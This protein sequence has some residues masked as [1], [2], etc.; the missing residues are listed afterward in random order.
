[1]SQDKR[2]SPWEQRW[3]AMAID[4]TLVSQAEQ[5]FGATMRADEVAQVARQDL[6][7]KEQEGGDL[8]VKNVLGQGGMG[9][10]WLA[11]Q[12]SIGREVAVKTVRDDRMSE[13]ARSELLREAWITG[14]LE[15]PN[16][17]PVHALSEREGRP[18]FVMKRVEGTAWLDAIHDPRKLPGHFAGEDVLEAHLEI[19]EQVCHAVHFAHSRD[20]LHRDIKPENVMLGAFGEVY[21]VDWG[22]AIAMCDIPGASGIPTLSHLSSPAGTPCFMAPEMAGV[23]LQNFGPPT[24]VYLLGATLHYLLT[25]RGR[26]EGNSLFAVMLAAY[27]SDPFDYGDDVPPMLAAICNTATQKDPALRYASAEELR[28]AIVEFR[29]HRDS[30]RVTRGALARLRDLEG[31]AALSEPGE[32]MV[33]AYSLYGECRFGFEQALGIWHAN[34]QAIAGLESAR[35]AMVKLELSQ[36]NASAARSMLTEMSAPAPK[37]S[38]RVL[39]L[40][41]SQAA[42]HVRIAALEQRQLQLDPVADRRQRGLAI[43]SLALTLLLL[44]VTQMVLGALTG[45]D[46]T[47]WQTFAMKTLDLA[48]TMGFVVGILKFMQLNRFGKQMILGL[49]WLIAAGTMMRLACLLQGFSTESSILFESV[50]YTGL[51]VGYG[52]TLRERRL[53]WIGPFCLLSGVGTL[54]LPQWSWPIRTAVNLVLMIMLGALWVRHGGSEQEEAAPSPS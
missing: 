31:L 54:L 52:I 32:M 16:I 47:D 18:L 20:I 24:D 43:I 22:I 1:M 42:E 36:N 34:P 41:R 38:E 35:A 7:F 53:L 17:I 48:V 19:F 2:V 33:Q 29:R 49:G 21:L 9:V 26:H 15:H 5:D 13:L 12:H 6:L 40:E 51:T 27:Q 39:A 44:N 4:E 10:V 11:D 3:A 45:H 50:L 25:K 30:V 37:L 23:E 14:R 8:T 46:F 28:R